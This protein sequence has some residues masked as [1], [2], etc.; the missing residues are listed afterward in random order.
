MN[1]ARHKLWLLSAAGLATLAAVLTWL[2]WRADAVSPYAHYQYLAALRALQQA[3][4]EL[5]AA[6]LAQRTGLLHNYDPLVQQLKAVR[7]G[8]RAIATLPAFLFADAQSTLA[9][10]IRALSELHQQK[11]DLVDRFQRSHAVLRNSRDYFPLAAEGL[12]TG[13]LAKRRDEAEIGRFVR[14]LL[15]FG[16]RS[17]PDAASQLRKQAEALAALPLSAADRAALDHLLVHARVIIEHQPEV[18]ALARRILDLPTA[19]RQEEIARLYGEAHERSLQRAGHYRV[20]LYAVALL[21]AAYLVWAYLRIEGDQRALAAAH[22][23]LIE[24]YEAQ[25]AA[26]ARLRLYATVFSNASE[27]M[28][29]T[30]A[31]SRIVA[32]NPAFARTLGHAP[33][34]LVGRTPQLLVADGHD[35][36]VFETIWRDVARVG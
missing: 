6:V 35:A 28:T 15:A 19:A 2:F 5:N 29:I 7:E 16:H 34:E 25:R 17:D 12:L 8:T 27:G 20:L 21:L 31:A 33:D 22:Q 3:D 13:G 36:S 24:R 30:D 9:E 4:V 18:D 10:K 32:V 1:A 23:A 14:T 11:A 26:E